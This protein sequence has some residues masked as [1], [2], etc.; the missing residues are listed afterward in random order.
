MSAT[1]SDYAATAMAKPMAKPAKKM[2]T[3]PKKAWDSGAMA[4]K[5]K[6]D[7]TKFAKAHAGM[8]GMKEL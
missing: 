4:D 2:G 3:A 8:M 1:R 7:K 5:Y 6:V